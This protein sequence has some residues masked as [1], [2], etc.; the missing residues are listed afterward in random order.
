MPTKDK[1]S[2]L[3]LSIVNYVRK[4]FYNIDTS[5]ESTELTSPTSSADKPAPESCDEAP[6]PLVT[7]FRSDVVAPSWD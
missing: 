6:T 7:T 2:R 5:F 4:K 3:V 1:H